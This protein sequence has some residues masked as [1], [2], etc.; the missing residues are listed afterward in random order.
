MT[1]FILDAAITDLTLYA[2]RIQHGRIVLTVERFDGAT[3]KHDIHVDHM[4]ERDFD[5]MMR[6][7]PHK[8]IEHRGL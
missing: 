8:V 3:V 6:E 5:R 7:R 4:T 1:D 2:R